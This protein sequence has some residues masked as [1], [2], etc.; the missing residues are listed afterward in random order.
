MWWSVADP[1]MP[2]I[3]SLSLIR[4]NFSWNVSPSAPYQF[5]FI[6]IC[7]AGCRSTHG[8]HSTVWILA[9]SAE[10]MRTPSASDAIDASS[11][12]NSFHAV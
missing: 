1:M 4:P 11:C 2:E 12:R 10:T 3:A 5:A 9:M 7:S 8:V 6:P